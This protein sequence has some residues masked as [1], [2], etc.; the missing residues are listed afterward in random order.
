MAR[1]ILQER[2]EEMELGE[3]A[4]TKIKARERSKK[5]ASADKKKRR[6]YRKIEEAGR[7]EGEEDVESVEGDFGGIGEGQSHG[8]EEVQPSAAHKPVGG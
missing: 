6:K 2:I 7:E 8:I 4:R 5:K 1:K 3:D